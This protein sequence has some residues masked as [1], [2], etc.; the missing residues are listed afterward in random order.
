[1]VGMEEIWSSLYFISGVSPL[2]IKGDLKLFSDTRILVN[3]ARCP[4]KVPHQTA[5]VILSVGFLEKKPNRGPNGG[6]Q[7]PVPSG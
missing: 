2:P 3:I 7:Q 6:D 1:M 4:N 5:V